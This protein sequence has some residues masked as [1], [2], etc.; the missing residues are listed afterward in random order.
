M[1][2]P[3]LASRLAGVLSLLGLLAPAG[4]QHRVGTFELLLPRARSFVVHGTLPIPQVDLRE[5]GRTPF[6][7]QLEGG[8]NPIV[9]AQVEVVAWREDGSPQVV[10]LLAPLTLADNASG[11]VRASVAVLYGDWQLPRPLVPTNET[12]PLLVGEGA[13]RLVAVDPLGRRYSAVLGGAPGI[14]HRGVRMDRE[15]HAVR[16]WR[17]SVV[18]TPEVE[19]RE[20]SVPS[21]GAHAYWSLYAGDSKL[22]LDLRLHAGLVDARSPREEDLP[23]VTYLREL[24]LELPQAWSAL[25]LVADPA[26]GPIL[27]DGGRRVVPILA[28]LPRGTCHA[29]PARSQLQRRLTVFR[30]GSAPAD[31]RGVWISGLAFPVHRGGEWSWSTKGLRSYFPQ[32]ATLPTFED[33]DPADWS[34]AEELPPGESRPETPNSRRGANLLRL[35]L[36]AERDQV[37]QALELGIPQAGLLGPRIGWAQAPLPVTPEL[38]ERTPRAYLLG[39][40]VAAAASQAGYEKLV[41]LHRARSSRQANSC[42]APSG[43]PLPLLPASPVPS[44]VSSPGYEAVLASG[45]RPAYDRGAPHLGEGGSPTDAGSIW[46]WRPLRGEALMD[47]LLTAKAL[48]WLGNDHLA[49]DDLQQEAVLAA[50]VDPVSGRPAQNWLGALVEAAQLEPGQGCAIG[51]EH[52]TALDAMAASWCLTPPLLR[53]EGT[54]WMLTFG[55]LL[56]CAAAPDGVVVRRLVTAEPGAE[57]RY[58]RPTLDVVALLHARRI[59]NHTL[60]GAEDD[61][62]GQVLR[63]QFMRVTHALTTPPAWVTGFDSS[64]PGRLMDPEPGPGARR[65]IPDPLWEALAE[66]IRLAPQRSTD[67]ESVL[68]SQRALRGAALQLGAGLRSGPELHIELLRRCALEDDRTSGLLV[69]YLAV[70][71]GRN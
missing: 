48:A 33:L 22:T 40:R 19:A 59:L 47:W 30:E 66:G 8:G 67:P 26:M 46:S 28:P 31:P 39:H 49:K 23:P 68:Q 17:T 45:R 52:A 56:G 9:P 70:L 37:R 58:E 10:E 63:D 25:P 21:L 11:G 60:V 42:W 64:G 2:A 12:I 35:G 1:L 51:A 36:E 5:P 16:S 44:Q 34:S 20:D 18:L 41:L 54:E 61:P 29:L 14:G 3:R 32:G 53:S 27:E 38:E 15:G 62:L 65:V 50:A 24:R 4:A 69:G 13:A 7:L 43:Q 6:A 55:H 71:E 57:A